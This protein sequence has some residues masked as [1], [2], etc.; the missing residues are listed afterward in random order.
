MA[1]RTSTYAPNQV[2]IVINHAA[3]GISHTL[4][5]FSEDSIV[6]VERLVDTFTEYVGADDTHTRVFNANSGARATVSLAQTSESNDVL[7][8]LHEFDREAMSADG[9]FEMLIKD[10]SGRSLYFSDEAYIAVIP[11]GGFSNQMNTRDWVI[12][13]TNTTFQHGGNQKV[14]PATADTLTALGVNLDARWL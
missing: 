14:S 2:T 3:S 1:G 8:F 11:Q 10:N 9:M 13:M 7:T 4:T 6:S 12:S 5:G